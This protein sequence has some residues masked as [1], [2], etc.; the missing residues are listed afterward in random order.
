MDPKAPGDTIWLLACGTPSDDG[1]VT[2]WSHLRGDLV[3]APE[4]ATDLE[5][6]VRRALTKAVRLVASGERF[7]PDW[8]ELLFASPG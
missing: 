4:F 7:P 1:T 3:S 6:L 5:E 2:T 8:D